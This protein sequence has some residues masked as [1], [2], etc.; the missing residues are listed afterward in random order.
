V[1]PRPVAARFGGLRVTPDDVLQVAAEYNLRACETFV[2]YL[3]SGLLGKWTAAGIELSPP[4]PD[5]ADILLPCWHRPPTAVPATRATAEQHAAALTLLESVGIPAGTVLG[6]DGV[7]AVRRREADRVA[8]DALQ[9]FA[10][11]RAGQRAAGGEAAQLAGQAGARGAARLAPGAAAAVPAEVLADMLIDRVQSAA[12]RDY[13]Y[14]VRDGVLAYWTRVACRNVAAR[15]LAQLVLHVLEHV[16]ALET[17]SE[18]SFG[19]IKHVISHSRAGNMRPATAEMFAMV[20]QNF[21]QLVRVS[22]PTIWRHI[23]LQ[24]VENA[25]P[26]APGPSPPAAA[27]GRASRCCESAEGCGCRP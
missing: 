18:E 16:R 11:L 4:L 9:G 8:K 26:R 25:P 20:A 17:P 7:P 24:A 19:A 3:D 10:A 23:T 12:V 27:F 22:R 5:G 2:E 14:A 15:P 6:G 1:L 13:L 21:D